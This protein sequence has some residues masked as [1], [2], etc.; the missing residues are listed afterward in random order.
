MTP[1]VVGLLFFLC[2]RPMK[3]PTGA[4]WLG[5]LSCA[6]GASAIRARLGCGR[7]LRPMKP[8]C[9]DE[10]LARYFG[11][12][13][14]SLFDDPV[15]GPLL[16]ALQADDPDVFAAIAEVDRSQIRANLAL[17]PEARLARHARSLRT[18]SRLRRGGT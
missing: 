1:R 4:L 16:R 6:N 11:P 5:G 2:Q 18:L 13:A 17:V 10:V 14:V 8:T 3:G 15:M 7:I 9:D 12:V